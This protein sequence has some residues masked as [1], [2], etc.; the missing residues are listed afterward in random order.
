[1]RGE[2]HSSVTP[3]VACDVQSEMELYLQDSEQIES[4]LRLETRIGDDG[5]VVWCGGALVQPLPEA[6]KEDLKCLIER[7]GA[8]P[9]LETCWD[10][11]EEAAFIRGVLPAGYPF[12]VVGREPVEFRCRCSET[13]VLY[14]LNTLGTEETE[15][16]IADG[17][18]VE[19]SCG[20]C[21]KQYQI[22]PEQLKQ[23]VE[24][25]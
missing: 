17:Q 1:M 9:K 18:D 12:V 14:S 22:K 24:R 4:S 5:Q 21:T 11:V 8:L 25:A 15:E 13:R 10:N 6:S 3:L 2:P 23:L 16:M 20:Y 19:I 7:L